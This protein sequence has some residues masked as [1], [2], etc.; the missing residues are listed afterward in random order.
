[1]A[2]HS[3]L[4]SAIFEGAGAVVKAGVRLYRQVT[5]NPRKYVNRASTSFG[6]AIF[7]FLSASLIA[8]VSLF[9]SEEAFWSFSRDIFYRVFAP[10]Y[11]GV[12]DRAATVVL[13]K[14]DS[15]RGFDTY[16]VKYQTHATIL[17]ALATFAPRAVFVDFAFID[18]RPDSTIADLKQVLE[19]YY[20]RGIHVYVPTHKIAS[21]G[22]D[23]GIRPDLLMLAAQ[24]R[25][26]LVS[27]DL[28]RI[29]WGTPVYSLRSKSEDRLTASVRIVE[30]FFPQLYS[31]LNAKTEFEIW[32]GLPPA[33][34]N[35]TRANDPCGSAYSLFGR[36]L[37]TMNLKVLPFNRHF[38][39]ESVDIPY[40]PVIYVNELM[41]GNKRILIEPVLRSKFIFYGSDLDILRDNYS[42]PVYS[43]R[44]GDRMLPGIFFHA[45]A[46]ENMID[47]QDHIKVPRGTDLS[48]IWWRDVESIAII[49][50]VL[51]FYRTFTASQSRIRDVFIIVGA[52]A[53]IA[54]TEFFYFNLAPSNWIGVFSFVTAAHVTHADEGFQKLMRKLASIRVG[55]H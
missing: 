10:L 39:S 8:S 17:Q 2:I 5:R 38:G 53:T 41:D 36:L 20:T 44:S 52:S 21:D 32:W 13:L 49:C 18:D 14:D 54:A 3:K 25:I 46:L 15:F 33:P 55:P 50:V 43:Y 27:F 30:D 28:G 22:S 19:E 24:D 47:L 48:A 6:K 40:S 12:Q 9:D 7:L 42:N 31:S 45:M 37:A 51:F 26:R 4:F 11:P 1:M 23:Q 34:I 16:P 29:V 35:C